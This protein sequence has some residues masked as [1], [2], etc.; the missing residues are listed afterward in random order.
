MLEIKNF[1][2]IYKGGKKA[3]D[4]INITVE[5]GDI[6]GIIQV[7]INVFRCE[8]LIMIRMICTIMIVFKM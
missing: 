4:N 3:A 8:L 7:K 6:Y 2:K 5:A 1:S